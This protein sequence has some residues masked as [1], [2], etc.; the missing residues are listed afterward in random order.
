[1]CGI[2]GRLDSLYGTEPPQHGRGLTVTHRSL[3]RRPAPREVF[4]LLQ[5][6]HLLPVGREFPA[7]PARPA[8]SGTRAE[9]R[10]EPHAQK[11]HC[12]TKEPRHVTGG[13]NRYLHYVML[14]RLCLYYCVIASSLITTA[15]A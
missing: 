10:N 13:V 14:E 6:G 12:V 9:F 1:M 5:S 15:G 8:R 2:P 11:R 3:Y 7:G 4:L